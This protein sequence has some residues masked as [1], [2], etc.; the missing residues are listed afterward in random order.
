[1]KPAG[2]VGAEEEKRLEFKENETEDSGQAK[3]LH[4]KMP[5]WRNIKNPI[6]SKWL[7]FSRD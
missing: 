3:P 1:L 2:E 7:K 5:S 4:K 6:A